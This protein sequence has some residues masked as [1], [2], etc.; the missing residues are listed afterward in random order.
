[1][2]KT[3]KP[4]GWSSRK[5]GEWDSL[6]KEESFATAFTDAMDSRGR[7]FGP[8]MADALPCEAYSSILDIAG[9]SGI[10]ACS[11]VER[12]EHMRAGVLE[13]PPVDKA[14]RASITHK[15][16]SD[17]VSVIGSDMFKEPLPTGFDIHLWSHVLHDWSEPEARLL[18]SKSRKALEPGGMIAIHDAHINADK[19]GPLP[20]ARYSVLLMHSTPGKCYSVGEISSFL[21][22][23]GFREI[24]YIETI[25]NRSIIMAKK[26]KA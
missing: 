14:A 15:G 8:A 10:Y 1:V 5:E 12:H 26:P 9:G 23:L 6:M 3:G 7:I 19:T 25:A 11:V 4:A 16:F 22:E 20:V 13:K 24:E 17:K 18:L 21:G 2:L